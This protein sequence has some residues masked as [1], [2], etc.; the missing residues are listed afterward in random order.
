METAFRLN[1]RGLTLIELLIGLVICAIVVAGIYRLFISQ[2]KAYVVQDQVVEL[3]QNVRSAM[4]VML[5]DLRM[6]GFDDDTTPLVTNPEPPVLP[7][8]TSVTVRYEYGNAPYEVLY[9]LD[10]GSVLNRLETKNGVSTTET[11]LENVDALTFSYGVDEDNDNA[12]D[13]RNGNGLADD[14]ISA[15]TVGNLK[16][17]T[18]RVSLTGRPAQVNPDLQS[19]T[20]RTLVSAVSLRN[21]SLMR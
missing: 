8:D 5:R 15:G 19:V 3:Q 14:W 20:P 4:E 21:L 11:I 6:A 9:R 17:V 13:D 16:I 10:A 18:V 7:G 1:K 12:M 2:G